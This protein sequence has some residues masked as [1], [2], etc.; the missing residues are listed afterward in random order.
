VVALTLAACS[1]KPPAPEPERVP[2]R[3]ELRAQHGLA[4][5]AL[6]AR[7]YEQAV[8]LYEQALVAAYARDD[9]REI[10]ELGYELAIVRLR[11]GEPALAEQQIETTI[12]ELERRG[13]RPF[14]ELRLVQALALYAGGR[15]EQARAVAA[16]VIDTPGIPPATAARAWHLTGMIAADRQD[17]PSLAAALAALSQR[18]EPALAADRLELEARQFALRGDHAAAL[19]AFDRTATL[20]RESGDNVG[21]ARALAFAGGSADA[22][23]RGADA[24]NFYLRAARSAAAEGQRD[25]AKGWLEAAQRSA[26]GS[27]RQDILREASV[28][29]DDLR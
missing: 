27:G 29:I 6:S 22:S 15:T 18:P 21:L 24:A 3:E 20:R 16:T 19:A 12:A 11:R 5:Y 8:P 10:G 23:G 28:A 14:A 2:A 1:S 13:A 7:Q 17:S 4:R 9:A 26:A 25:K